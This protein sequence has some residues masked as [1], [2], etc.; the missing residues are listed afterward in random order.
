MLFQTLNVA[1]RG[2]GLPLGR[3]PS[4]VENADE[5]SGGALV[6]SLRERKAS[7]MAPLSK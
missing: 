5:E 1:P 2:S 7:A 3:Q 4:L 6:S